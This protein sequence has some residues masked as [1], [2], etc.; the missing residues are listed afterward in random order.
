MPSTR[1]IRDFSSQTA[2]NDKKCTIS[3]WFKF[4]EILSGGSDR[5]LFGEYNGSQD[6]AYIY[7]R[8]D[9]SIGV[10]GRASNS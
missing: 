6:H 1:L 10:Y 5:W 8:N 3:F 9:K 2:T 4:T 7:L